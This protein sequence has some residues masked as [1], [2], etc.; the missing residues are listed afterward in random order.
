MNEDVMRSLEVMTIRFNDKW[1]EKKVKRKRK[2]K[3]RK[4][5][6]VKK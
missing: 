4:Q 6:T 2:E 5:Q 3:E 1:M